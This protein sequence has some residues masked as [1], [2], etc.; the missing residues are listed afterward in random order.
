MAR[1]TVAHPRIFTPDEAAD[2]LSVGRTSI[3]KLVNEGKLRAVR[4]PGIYGLR[5]R[6][7]DLDAYLRNA[8]PVAPKRVEDG[9]P[10]RSRSRSRS[11][12]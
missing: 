6:A 9:R 7:E 10:K 1:K 8:K 2:M 12:A 11:A 3:Y 4:V 5:I